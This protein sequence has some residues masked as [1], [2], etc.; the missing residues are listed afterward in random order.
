M[1]PFL[2]GPGKTGK[3]QVS[4]TRKKPFHFFRSCKRAFRLSSLLQMHGDRNHD[5]K[6]PGQV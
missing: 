2:N 3:G 4:F 6:R 5:F 1:D